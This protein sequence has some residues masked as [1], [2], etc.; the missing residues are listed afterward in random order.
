MLVYEEKTRKLKPRTDWMAEMKLYLAAINN[1]LYD[2][3]SNYAM[4]QTSWSAKDMQVMGRH[5]KR[6]ATKPL[7]TG[8]KCR[9]CNF[10]NLDAYKYQALPPHT[11]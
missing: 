4:R 11:I 5:I 1:T 7:T 2:M 6:S 8:K 3:A 9:A 10:R